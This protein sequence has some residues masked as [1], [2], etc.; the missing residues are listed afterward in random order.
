MMGHLGWAYISPQTLMIARPSGCRAR[1]ELL[2]VNYAWL[3]VMGGD[4]I[5]MAY[6][7]WVQSPYMS[8]CLYMCDHLD[9]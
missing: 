8:V 4:D 6:N 5:I 9:I 7:E 3:A 2:A 1:D